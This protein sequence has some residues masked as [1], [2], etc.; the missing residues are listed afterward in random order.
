MP[1]V[2]LALLMLK[3]EKSS[4]VL[5]D[6]FMQVWLYNV[7]LSILIGLGVGYAARKSLQLASRRGW[8]DRPSL[9]VFGFALAMATISLVSLLGANDLLAVF[10]AAIAFAW[11][12]WFL[13]ETGGSGMQEAADLIFNFSF[14]V[15]FGAILPWHRIEQVAQLGYL[16]WVCLGILLL[17]RIPWVWA[18]SRWIPE[19]KNE[20]EVLFTGWFGPMGVGAIFYS[21]L[22]RDASPLVIPIVWT[23]VL[24]SIV[25][26]GI[27]VPLFHL[28]TTG[29]LPLPIGLPDSSDT[30]NL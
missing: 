26:H 11:D 9:L 5:A 15:L 19:L 3:R 23:I 20:R 4:V 27:T 29:A 17:R 6:W 1:L 30:V 21:L 2:A 10:A 12:D 16:W 25:A 22:V 8:A 7:G 18:V 13:E 14:F 28:S 24:V